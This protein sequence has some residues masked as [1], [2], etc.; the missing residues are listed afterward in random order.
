M[1]KGKEK[2]KLFLEP[3]DAKHLKVSLDKLAE[4]RQEIGRFYQVVNALVAAAGKIEGDM[5][6]VRKHITSKY[7]LPD[8][9]WVVNFDT[10]EIITEGGDGPVM[11]E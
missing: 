4:V 5:L 9:K 3:D 1:D 10:N 11:T 7:R 8:L 2:E 6:E